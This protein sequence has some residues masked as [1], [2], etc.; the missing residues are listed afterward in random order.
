MSTNPENLTVARVAIDL[1]LDRTFDYLLPPEWRDELGIGSQVQVPFGNS[2]RHGFILDLSAESARPALKP[3]LGP[4]P[5]RIRLPEKLIELGRWIADYYLCTQEQA[6]RALLP[7]AV[8]SGR[9]RPGMERFCRLGERE[10]A[11]RY[12]LEHAD[13]A[14]AAGR[15]R[16][17]KQLLVAAELPYETLLAEA[18]ATPAMLATL[19]KHGLLIQEKRR[20]DRALFPEGAVLRSEPLPPTPEQAAALAIFDELLESSD[21]S[22]VLLLHGVTNSGKTEV[23]LQAIARTLERGQGA[24]MLVPEIALTPQTVRR[25]RARFGDELS[26]LHSQLTDAER[27]D[28]WD[29]IRRGESRIVIGARSALFAPLAR[30]GLIIVDE[31]HESTYK[32]TEAPRYHARDVAVMRGRLEGAVVILGSAT[33]AAETS[34][35]VECGKYR[36]AE[37]RSKVENRLDPVIRVVDQRLAGPPEPGKSNY[38]S[39]ILIEAVHDRLRRGEQSI[40][41][42]NRR[43]YA[44]V[45]LC[46]HCGFEARCPDCAVT[47]TYSRQRQTLACHLCGNVIAAPAVCPQCGAPDIRYAGV[48]TEKIEAAA[49]ALFRE[50]RVGRM[51]SDTMRHPADYERVLDQFRRGELDILIG[52][53]MIAKGLHFP[54]VTLVGLVNA[55]LG[56]AMPDFRA[57]ERV[58]QLITQVAG[59]AGRGDLRG[60]VIIQT[61]NPDNETIQFAARQDFAGFRQF[62]LEIRKLLNYPPYSHLIAVHFRGPEEAAVL[63]RASRLVEE[64]RPYCHEGIQLTGPEPAPI[65]RIKGKFRYLVLLRGS[66]LR[67][68]RRRLRE[69]LLHDHRTDSDVEV[70]A[71][72][73]ALALL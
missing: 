51:D 46:D 32:Q 25:F 22:R 18:N 19:E 58:F 44:R 34:Y 36:L 72:V 50:A 8:R 9:I 37:M 65:E 27:F 47:Y 23:Y 73:D 40:L 6:I 59:R 20:R 45:M 33:P 14:R 26:V 30:P 49:M 69:L 15:L 13:D 1:A 10:A 53:Q 2:R 54:N 70:Y 63:A 4:V 21:P 28:Q 41:F 43:G 60:E 11:E 68:A 35:N 24:I 5:N 64:L 48:G 57:P 56:L 67:Q 42:L 66:A 55:D 31:E 16:V 71:D 39:R 61:R 3:I 7:G 62:D 52:T 38:F 29:R 17:L 12:L